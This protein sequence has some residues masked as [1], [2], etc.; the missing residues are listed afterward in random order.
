MLLVLRAL[1]LG[2][3][4]TAV[5]AL[6]GLAA[7]FPAHRRLLAAPRQLAPLL[8]LIRGIDGEEVVERI[9]DVRGLAAL[10][11][12]LGR[13]A[14]AANLH[15]RGPQSHRRLLELAPERL[16]AFAH[17]DVPRSLAGARWMTGEHEVQRW[18]RMLADAGVPC[19]PRALDIERPEPGERE[20]PVAA[21]G[22]TVL[23]PGAA[24]GARRWPAERWAEL[25]RAEARSGRTV[26]LS[27]GPAEVPLAR[28]IARSAGLSSGVV[29]AGRTG[30]GDLALVVAAAG[31]VVCGD[32][33]VGH[34]ATA[35]RTPSVLLFGPVAPQ[36]WG[37]P[38]ERS[39]HRVLWTGRR[40]DPHAGSADR[41]LLE[42]TVADV[43]V[44]LEQLDGHAAR[45][46]RVEGPP[47]GKAPD[48][49][50]EGRVIVREDADRVPGSG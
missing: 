37:P 17:P 26:L 4:L 10:P 33:G 3:L 31:R 42:I 15:G 22:A 20:W 49:V 11:A 29:L 23:H 44:A 14:I 40:G 21:H 39:R 48:R 38:P 13:V 46:A 18:C 7:A 47:R 6:R 41:G 12:D 34:L 19:D 28:S 8:Q 5:P 2:D 43:L 30:V 35:L 24:S 25:A 27:G 16:L 1:G 36:E 32:T 50:V 45:A 9:V